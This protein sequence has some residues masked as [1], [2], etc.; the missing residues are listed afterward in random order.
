MLRDWL[1][2]CVRDI[3]GWENSI[4]EDGASSLHTLQIIISRDLQRLQDNGIVV[5]LFRLCCVAIWAEYK[6]SVPG[7]IAD[8]P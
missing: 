1:L 3:R 6:P 5:S 2:S 8:I 7:L 4:L